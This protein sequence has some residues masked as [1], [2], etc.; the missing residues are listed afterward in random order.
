[1]LKISVLTSTY[2]RS[3]LLEN[4]YSSLIKNIYNNIKIEWL[5]MDD[6]STDNTEYVVK[7]FPT[8]NQLEIK[9]F[10][11]ENQG[12]M[13]AI[14]NLIPN[15]TGDLI[16]ECDSDDYFIENVFQIIEEEY[17]KNKG[18][19]KL[20]ALCFLKYDQNGNNMGKDLDEEETTMFD[21]YFKKEEDGEKS[22]VYFSNIRKNYKYK[23]EKNEKFITEARLHHE[24]DF[25]YKIKCINKPIMICEYQE[26]GYTKNIKK[27]FLENPY[28]Y[29]E[30]FKEILM[31]K[32]F[33]GIT[34]KKR[35]Y[36]IKHYILFSYLTKQ[37]IN[38]KEVTKIK[39][40]ILI[41]LLYLPGIKIKEKKF[42][43]NKQI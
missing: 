12:K 26:E 1:M 18:N 9:Y 36:A 39:D 24:M 17:N 21:L 22:L 14:N 35:I 30:Y 40:K 19:S 31:R 37:K 5:I 6:G 33:K 4:L 43:N 29:F 28:G 42:K 13:K 41:V 23:L 25:K 20:Y 2:N 11:Q 16:I 34:F 38:L 27:Q 8:K 3:N 7:Q 10:K 15:S 32:D